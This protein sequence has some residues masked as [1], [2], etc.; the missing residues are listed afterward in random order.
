EAT[1]ITKKSKPSRARARRL[2]YGFRFTTAASLFFQ[3]ILFTPHQMRD[4][5]LLGV[6]NLS[7]YFKVVDEH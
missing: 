1:D 6:R 7:I 2:P 3:K 4:R 5:A